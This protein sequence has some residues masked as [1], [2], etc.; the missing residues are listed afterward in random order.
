MKRSRKSN[1]ATHAPTHACYSR[2]LLKTIGRFLPRRGLPLRMNA[3][4]IGWTPRLLVMC[5]IL[6]TFSKAQS[7]KDRFADARLATVKMYDSR[8]R[9]GR[10]YQGFIAALCK[11]SQGFLELICAALRAS[12]REIAASGNGDHWKVEGWILFGADGTKVEC[13][14]TAANEK[15]FGCGGRSKST[16]QQFLTMLLHLGTGLPWGFLRGGACQSE[17]EHLRR[18]IEW[19]PANSMLVADAGFTGYD[20]LRAITQSGHGFIIR[21]GSNVRLLRKLGYAV[22]EYEGIVYLWPDKKKKHEANPLVLRLVVLHDGKKAVHLLCSVLEEEL[23]SDRA[24]GA[25][26]R[27]RWEIELHYRA[28][29]QTLCRRKLC[30]DSP[31]HARVE[32]DWT[33]TGLWILALAAVKEQIEAGESPHRI[34]VAGALRVLRQ[35]MQE[36]NRVCARGTLSRQLRLAVKDEYKRSRPKKARHWPHKK[37]ERLPGAPKIRMATELEVLQ[38]QELRSLPRAA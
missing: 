28:L 10:S 13:P 14:M 31:A 11:S 4:R 12:V 9:P 33:V 27:M 16:P 23:L 26:Y 21:V 8:R 30:S 6:M 29:K 25:I 24:I 3:G 19:L 35:A 5:V 2:E 22:R 1:A 18:M 36:P 17:R 37:K 34:S 15:A 20:L 32:L 38:A 7:L